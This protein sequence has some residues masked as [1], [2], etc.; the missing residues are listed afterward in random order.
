MIFKLRG[1]SIFIYNISLRIMKNSFFF[2]NRI[3]AIN[4]YFKYILRKLELQLVRA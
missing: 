4:N 2:F 1:F 3:I